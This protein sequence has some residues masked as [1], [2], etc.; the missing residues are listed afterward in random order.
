MTAHERRTP[1]ANRAEPEQCCAPRSANGSLL[2][3]RLTSHARWRQALDFIL[4][5]PQPS[6]N[7]PAFK[8]VA[9]ILVLDAL[10]A[11]RMSAPLTEIRS[12]LAHDRRFNEWPVS[13]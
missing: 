5:R 4:P 9:T 11:R 13:R 2:D 12:C 7:A 3:H 10:G 8:N 1:E 6:R